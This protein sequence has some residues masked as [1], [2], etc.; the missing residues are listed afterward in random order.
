MNL[1]LTSYVLLALSTI[2]ASMFA[3][4]TPVMTRPF[5]ASLVVMAVSVVLM[6]RAYRKGI[7]AA[8]T[9]GGAYDFS[10]GLREANGVLDRLAAMPDPDCA[11]IHR[12]LDRVIDGPL[13]DFIQA[14]RQLQARFGFGPYARVIG[15]FSRGE[16]AV[17]R[18]WSAAVDGYPG[19]AH[20]W[21]GRAR[22]IFADLQ[23]SVN[24]LAG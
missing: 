21:L 1:R 13:F 9:A 20:E 22:D 17:N 19:E 18:A 11:A 4:R 24:E 5:A 7:A 14:S 3:A 10:G 2:A 12:E 15:E 6:R 16:R 23:K 8:D